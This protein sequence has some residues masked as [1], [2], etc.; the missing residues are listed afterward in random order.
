MKTNTVLHLVVMLMLYTIDTENLPCF[1]GNVYLH[2][3]TAQKK[4]SVRIDIVHF[5]TWYAEYK[6]FAV[7][8]E[9]N[10]YKL[11]LGTYHGTAR[12]YNAYVVIY[13]S[14]M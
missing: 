2:A 11:S 5:K 9:G 12:K 4:Y 1:P 14:Y 7:A 13:C 3:I 6:D 10:K 8:N